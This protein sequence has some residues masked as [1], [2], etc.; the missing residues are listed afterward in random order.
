MSNRII[1]RPEW[2]AT[3]RNGFGSRPL[4][5][6]SVFQHHSVT[7]APAVNA[8]LAQDIAAVKVLERIGDSRFGSISYNFIIPP[9]GRIFEGV[10]VER[11]GAHT[12]G[13]NTAGIGICCIG[14]YENAELT[15]AQ[16]D[17][18]IWLLAWLRVNGKLLEPAPLRPHSAVSATAC[19]GRNIKR[20]LTA[21]EDASRRTAVMPAPVQEP[22]PAPAPAHAIVRVT[23][24]TLN[25]RS[26]PGT[27][28]QIVQTVKRGEVFTIV[29]AQSGWGRLKSGA[30]WISLAYTEVAKATA[31]APRPT[32]R[33]A[34]N[35][36][37]L[38][39]RGTASANGPLVARMP[40]GSRVELV[41]RGK[42]WHQVRFNGRLGWASAQ[43]LR[44]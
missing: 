12:G 3:G 24:S 20:E 6:K 23:A 38:M 13:H 1:S 41:Q 16:R 14:N 2:G 36:A 8:T 42:S 15:P 31:A 9:S 17:A 10:S 28:H 30:G 43:W 33:V 22:A 7:A 27:G 34:T 26:G 5:A 29:E 39:L 44:G 25:V 35:G 21:I 40:N 32:M 18:L 19:P 4:P 11:I 37:A